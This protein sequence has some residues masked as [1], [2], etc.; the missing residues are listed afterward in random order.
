MDRTFLSSCVPGL[1]AITLAA[2]AGCGAQKSVAPVSDSPGASA[3]ATDRMEWWRD[4]RFGMFIHWGLYAIPAGEWGG[5][6][7]YGEW[8]RTEAQIPREEYDTLLDQ[9]NPVKFD[10][11]A[12][13][14]LAK[15]AGMK[16]IVITSKHHDGFALF[17]SKDSDFDVMATPFKRDIL[18]ELA[19]ACKREGITLCFY[20]SIMDWH[21]PDY[22]PIRD[23]EKRP[24]ARADFDRYVKYMKGQLTELLTN[25]GDIGILWFDGEWEGTWT[26]ERGQDLYNFVRATSP[27]TII[28]NR[29]DKGRAGMSGITKAKGFLGDYDTPEQEIPATGLPGIDWETCMTMNGHWGYN[30]ADKN[31]K[32]TEDLIHKLADIASKGGNFLLNVGPTAA[33]EIPP[34]SVDRLRAMGR[35]MDVNAESIRGTSASPFSA[36]AWGRCTQRPLGGG[37]RLYLHV[38][39]WPADGALVVPGIYNQPRGAYLLADASRRPLDVSRDGDALVIALPSERTDAIDSVVVLDIVGKPDIADPPTIEADTD[40]F[41]RSVTVKVR[42]DRQNAQVRFTTDGSEPAA[43]SPIASGPIRLDESATV[44]ARVFREGRP[45]SPVAQRTFARVLPTPAVQATGAKPGSLAFEYFEGDW[46][47]LPDFDRLTPALIGATGSFDLGQKTSENRFAFRYRGFIRVPEDGAYT[48]WTSSDDGS[49]LWI[50][51]ELVVDNDGL[52]SL[53]EKR[54]VVA[55]AAGL[56]P[57]T[58]GYFEKTGG[59]ELQVSYAGPGI[60]RRPVPFSAF[61]TAP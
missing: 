10:A 32:S 56:H 3:R 28:N 24:T 35:W 38:F 16:Y 46:D 53:S 55:L 21:H 25:Y 30:K 26:H 20:H 60:E 6:T 48:F 58:I 42:T 17:D 43:A 36:L 39:D 47:K 22:T 19:G 37:T 18:K 34:E 45:V 33:G 54:G 8:I 50:G 13:V 11:D 7:T 57:I 5:K 14:R 2:M 44:K 12:W 40:I 51:E 29:V 23:W 1:I 59:H 61:F 31:F 15:A 52:H 4:A 9:F 27:R 49:R 41:V